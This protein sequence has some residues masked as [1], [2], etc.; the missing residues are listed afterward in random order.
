MEA[1]GLG[2]VVEQMVTDLEVSRQLETR[3]ATSIRGLYRT[4]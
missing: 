3:R 1:E 4:L 2:D